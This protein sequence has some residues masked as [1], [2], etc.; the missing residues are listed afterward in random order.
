MP[1]QTQQLYVALYGRRVAPPEGSLLATHHWALLAGPETEGEN[2]RGRRYH[3]KKR[4]TD[5]GTFV[6]FYEGVDIPLKA[7]NMLDIHIAVAKI[8]DPVRLEAE[9][10]LVPVVQA[11]QKWDCI[12]WIKSALAALDSSGCLGTKCPPWDLV[13]RTGMQYMKS[14]LAVRRPDGQVSNEAKVTTYDLME[15]KE[16]NP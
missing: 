11:D 13:E 5:E 15:G 7:T 2:E 16:I 1:P 6:W 10:K 4:A 12:T 8:H 9:L 3:V 14:K